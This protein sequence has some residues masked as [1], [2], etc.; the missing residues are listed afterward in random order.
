MAKLPQPEIEPVLI[1]R[2]Y[3]QHRNRA[4]AE[5]KLRE[6]KKLYPEPRFTALIAARRNAQGQFSERGQF[7]TFEVYDNGEE[8]EPE[9]E[10]AFDSP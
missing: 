4:L 9:Y 8:E 10:G 7:F 5:R 1:L 6:Y 3:G 2:E